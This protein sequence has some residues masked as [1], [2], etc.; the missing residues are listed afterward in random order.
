MKKNGE[1]KLNLWAQ[2]KPDQHT[3]FK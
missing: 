2:I 3:H 1:V